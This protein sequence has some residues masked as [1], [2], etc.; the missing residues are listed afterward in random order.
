[1]V[2]ELTAVDVDAARA[3]LVEIAARCW[4]LRISSF[5]VREPPDGA[6]GRAAKALGCTIRQT[7]PPGGGLM[8]AIQDRAGLLSLLEPELRRRAGA[9]GPDAQPS[10]AFRALVR[11]EVIP[12]DGVLLPLLLGYWS[13]SEAVALGLAIPAPFEHLLA[14]W[15]PGGGTPALPVPFAAALDDY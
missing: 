7:Y 2:D 15:F 12:E 8:G 4:G 6:A 1:V 3:L 9:A 11:G 14:L 13:L 10:T 5:Q